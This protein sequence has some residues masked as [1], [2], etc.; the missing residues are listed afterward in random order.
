MTIYTSSLDSDFY[1]MNMHL[2]N[3]TLLLLEERSHE[4]SMLDPIFKKSPLSIMG[5]PVLILGY[6]IPILIARPVK[7]LLFQYG[8]SDLMTLVD[9]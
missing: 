2:A 1:G 7:G 9:G 3:H 5:G 6:T 8:D 4:I